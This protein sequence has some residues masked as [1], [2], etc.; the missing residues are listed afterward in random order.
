MKTR[1]FII[2]DDGDYRQ[3]LSHHLSTHWPQAD[4]RMYD[5]LESGRLPDDFLG[6]Q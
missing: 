3:L 5:P 6:R 4:V 2:D 1:F